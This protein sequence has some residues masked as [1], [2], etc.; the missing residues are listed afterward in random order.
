MM[1]QTWFPLWKV[2]TVE[3]DHF[4]KM[5][6]KD[7]ADFN[8][9][10]LKKEVIARLQTTTDGRVG[11]DI[12]AVEQEKAKKEKEEQEAWDQSQQQWQQQQHQG[13]YNRNWQN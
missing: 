10:K 2:I 13:L 3:A 6:L 8:Y 11:M 7:D 9:A 4:L 5:A 12:N 1:I